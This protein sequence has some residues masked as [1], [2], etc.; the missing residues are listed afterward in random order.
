M[1]TERRRRGTQVVE[2]AM[3]LPLLLFL[4]L[5]VSEGAYMIRV[6]QVLNNAAREGAR[7]AVQRENYDPANPLTDC[8]T[9]LPTTS[10][11]ALCQAIVS[12]AYN[13]GISQG[14]GANQC[15]GSANAGGL[16]ITINQAYPMPSASGGFNI[17]GTQVTVLCPY[18]LNFLPR[19]PSFGVTGTVNLRGTVVFRNFGF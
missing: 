1:A 2:L 7:L 6:H 19:L 9:A 12:Y 18:N 16:N 8:A 15:N 13:N 17:N 3:V 14:T 4:S 10:Q 5:A 11:G